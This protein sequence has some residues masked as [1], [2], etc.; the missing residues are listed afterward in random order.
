LDG[1][2]DVAKLDS[3]TLRP[4]LAT[5]PIWELL[6]DLVRQYA[7]IAT[8]RHLELRAVQ[9]RA[10]VRTDRVLLRRILQNYLANALRYTRHG[11]V[12]IGVRRRGGQIL[13]RVTDTGP[14]IAEHQCNA[15]YDEFTR[16]E[17]VS[18]W[19]EK[20]LGLGLAICDRIGR[21]LDH[22]LDLKTLPGRGSSFGVI[23][24]RAAAAGVP[25]AL[26]AESVADVAGTSLEGL[27]ALCIDNDPTILDGMDALLGRW[28]VR[29]AKA[30]GGTEALA[31][32]EAGRIDVVLA[33]FH[34]DDGDDGLALLRR[35]QAASDT[36]LAAALVTADYD[37]SLVARAREAGWPVLR[38]P[39]KPAALRA[40]L[41]SVRATLDRAQERAAAP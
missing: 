23:V 21:L 28:G 12:V 39:V 7:P 31:A 24:P 3:G 32:L 6:A 14:G 5:F 13:V 41:T 4:D 37:P 20:G 26:A 8:A 10:V 17:R 15:I 29:V 33:D 38:K 9:T 30:R 22:P 16:L 25:E 34:L 36:V 2:L 11:G 19:G 1:L 40:V 18:P 35:L 27:I